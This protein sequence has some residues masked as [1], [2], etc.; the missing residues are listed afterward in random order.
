M[1]EKEPEKIRQAI[2][3]MAVYVSFMVVGLIV[4]LLIPYLMRYD[5]PT[6]GSMTRTPPPAMADP[7]PRS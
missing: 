6:N 4:A 7:T 2:V 3:I 1:S 5:G